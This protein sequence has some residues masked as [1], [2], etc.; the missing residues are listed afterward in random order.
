MHYDHKAAVRLKEQPAS[1]KPPEN[2]ILAAA[3]RN[4]FLKKEL[5]GFS[6]FS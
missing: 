4:L 6:I 5:A 1:K 2:F 3:Y